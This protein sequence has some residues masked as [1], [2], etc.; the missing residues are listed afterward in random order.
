VTRALNQGTG[1]A[2]NEV[3]FLCSKEGNGD[4]VLSSV[5]SRQCIRAPVLFCDYLAVM[6][7]AS[8]S[9][10]NL[11]LSSKRP[12]YVDW[13]STYIGRADY[14]ASRW[15]VAASELF[16]RNSGSI[17][18][19]A[20][21][22]H[23]E[24]VGGISND[25]NRNQLVKF[26]SLGLGAGQIPQF[27]LDHFP[28]ASVTTVELLQEMVTEIGPRVELGSVVCNVISA[29]NVS[30]AGALPDS[31]CRSNVIVGDA[32]E[33]VAALAAN[34]VSSNKDLGMDG[35]VSASLGEETD[36][37]YDVIMVDV[38]D[39]QAAVYS[40]RPGEGFSNH[41][42]DVASSFA[43][44][45]NIH[46]LLRPIPISGANSSSRAIAV[47]HIHNDSSLVDYRA[48]IHVVFGVRNV[49]ELRSHASIIFVCSVNGFHPFSLAADSVHTEGWHPCDHKHEFVRSVKEFGLHHGVSANIRHAGSMALL[50]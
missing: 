47:F 26:L 35:T 40:G 43:N 3:N 8:L 48:N 34:T 22:R 14:A 38:Y 2:T 10:S 5:P 41:N 23:V 24:T 36:P 37:Y 9:L 44:I 39:S 42:A 12:A 16:H 49:V 1:G 13:Y 17:L 31:R 18:Q 6:V 29:G 19:D 50:C 46:R 28:C 11:I 27:V 32:F 15:T 25:C 7:G 4:P 21:T 20:Y 33:V 45:A 30:A